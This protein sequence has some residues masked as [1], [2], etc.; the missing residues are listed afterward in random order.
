MINHRFLC[1]S[2]FS[3][4][5]WVVAGKA[6]PHCPGRFHVHPDS[7]QTGAAWMKNVVSFDK[8]KLTNNLLDENGHVSI[9]KKNSSLLKHVIKTYFRIIQIILNSMH[10]YQP[11]VHC[12]YSPSSKADDILVQQTQAFRTFTFPETKFIGV[13]AYQ[14]HRIT[15]LK[16]A[17]NPFA[18]GPQGPCLTCLPW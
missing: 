11:R 16:I 5:S 18:K 7:P 15:Q 2:S 9:D 12:V 1:L 17:S 8:L 6:D 3:S 13:T 10:R 4:S 14:N